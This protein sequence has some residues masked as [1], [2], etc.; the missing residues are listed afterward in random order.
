MTGFRVRYLILPALLAVPFRVC[1]TQAGPPTRAT[2]DGYVASTGGVRL[3]YRVM[4]G[5]PDT[6]IMIHGGP[7]AGMN[8]MIPDFKPLAAH[9]TLIFYD[10]RGGGRS[11]LP[12]DTTLLN[13]RY[14]VDDLEAVR[15]HFG[16]ERVAVLAHSFGPLIVALYAQTH[17]EHVARMI[18]IGAIGPRRD[19][20]RAWWNERQRQMGTVDTAL[21]RRA[22][23]LDSTLITGNE[24]DPVATCH[25]RDRVGQALAVAQKDT[26]R[27]HG[28]VCDASPEAITY[29]FHYTSQLTPESLGEWDF[30]K[31]LRQVTAPLLV[32]YGDQDTS[33]VESQLEWAAAV[34]NGVLVVLPGT[35][36]GPNGRPEAFFSLVSSFLRG[37]WPAG[38]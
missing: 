5:G 26:I 27:W 15:R 25:E 28:T 18:F 31:S 32:V 36:H 12:A 6:L 30:T 10:Q 29:F 23:A 19:E 1:A 7:G 2:N 16:L 21:T 38:R 11:T 14:F 35:G 24:P 22:R 34:P 37:E 17:P 8:A 33:P 9:H 3:Y 13:A 4:G 20:A